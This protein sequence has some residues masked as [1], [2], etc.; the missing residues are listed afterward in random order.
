MQPC[1]ECDKP[2]HVTSGDGRVY[3]K[4][5]GE[6]AKSLPHEADARGWRAR[7]DAM[8]EERN[9]YY[10]LWRMSQHER[11]ELLQSCKSMMKELFKT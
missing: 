8:S 5:C 6:S 3:C 7:H 4:D 2:F 10:R 1:I 11:N 9:R